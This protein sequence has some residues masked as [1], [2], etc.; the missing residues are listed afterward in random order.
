MNAA[1]RPRRDGVNASMVA[2]PNGHWACLLDFLCE[3]FPHVS[4]EQWQWR[5]SRGDVMNESAQALAADQAYTPQRKI[6]YYR[7]LAQEALIPVQEAIVFEDDHLVVADKPHFLP[8]TPAG[9]FVQQTLLVRLQQRLNEPLLV[10]LHRLDRETAGLVLF[11]RRP[12]D[13]AAYQGLFRQ[14][15]IA[16]RYEAHAPINRQLQFPLQRQSRLEPSSVFMQMH[17]VAGTVNASTRIRLRSELS[18]GIGLFELEPETGAKHQLR[19]HMSA[20]GMP[21]L[22]D[23]IYPTLHAFRKTEEDSFQAPLKLLAREL[24]FL[25]PITGE[26]RRF[27]SQLHL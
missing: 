10:P 1:P 2:L 6:Y 12:Q 22:G 7:G 19:V 3:K 26:E 20:L 4:R 18:G 15:H 13:R 21:I 14:R 17:E 24:H 5:F 27:F 23:R 16:K 25:D 9:Q 8:V 11:A